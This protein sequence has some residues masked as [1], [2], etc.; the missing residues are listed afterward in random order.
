[1]ST[2]EPDA[3]PDLPAWDYVWIAAA[4]VAVVAAVVIVAY[5]IAAGAL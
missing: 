1:M 2:L 3:M 4:V 5:A